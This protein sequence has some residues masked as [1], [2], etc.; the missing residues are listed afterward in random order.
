M[1]IIWAK[2]I[3]IMKPATEHIKSILN[4]DL[5]DKKSIAGADFTIAVDGINSVGGIII[6][7]LL[8]QLGSSQDHSTEL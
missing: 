7:E 2:F 1:Y 6:P 8:K 4:L 3:L 5:V